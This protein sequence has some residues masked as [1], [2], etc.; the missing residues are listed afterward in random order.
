MS[1]YVSALLLQI[2]FSRFSERRFC[3]VLIR[4]EVYRYIRVHTIS[5]FGFSLE[6]G[7]RKSE[8][9]CNSLLSLLHKIEHRMNKWFIFTLYLPTHHTICTN[10]YEGHGEKQHVFLS[11]KAS[12]I[13]AVAIFAEYTENV[14]RE[15]WKRTHPDHNMV[16]R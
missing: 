9:C 6:I 1:R 3:F 16:H 14:R 5:K 10:W 2:H 12:S 11:F 8:S 13:W 7:K 15:K 4:V